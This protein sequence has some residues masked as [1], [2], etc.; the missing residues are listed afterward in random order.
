MW[1]E[2]VNWISLVQDKLQLWV[3]VQAARNLVVPIKVENVLTN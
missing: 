1:N 3:L 2:S